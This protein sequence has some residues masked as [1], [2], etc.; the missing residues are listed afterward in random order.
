MDAVTSASAPSSTPLSFMTINLD[1]IASV[2]SSRT[3]CM[4]PDGAR[5][6]ALMARCC[7]LIGLKGQLDGKGKDSPAPSIVVKIAQDACAELGVRRLPLSMGDGWC[8]SRMLAWASDAVRVGSM[9]KL[10]TIKEGVIAAEKKQR[11]V[12]QVSGILAEGSGLVLV[13][14]GMYPEPVIMSVEEEAG[15][16]NGGGTDT[17]KTL[18]TLRVSIWRCDRAVSESNKKD[19]QKVY[20]RYIFSL[21]LCSP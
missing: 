15:G 12:E 20:C 9:C 3:M 13:E 4:D 16:G 10:K 8:W 2:L 11:S 17:T 19:M 5:C 14:P 21:S 7:R 6:L 1:C 18:G